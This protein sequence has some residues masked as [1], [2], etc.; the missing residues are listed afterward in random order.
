MHTGI[1]TLG[2]LYD[3]KWRIQQA[4]KGKEGGRRGDSRGKK[5]GRQILRFLDVEHDEQTD[6]RR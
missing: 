1:N 4:G 3:W 6:L 2:H 5:G